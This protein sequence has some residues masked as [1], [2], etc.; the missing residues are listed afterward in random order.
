VGKLKKV[1]IGFGIVIL[2]FFVL[3]AIGGSVPDSEYPSE[4]DYDKM[5]NSQ[6]SAMAVDWD[7]RDLMRNFDNYEN[8]I[9]FVD[10]TVTNIQRSMNSVNL[11]MDMGTFSCDDLMFLRV[12]ENKWLE[13]DELS[14]FVEVIELR[15][16]GNSNMFTG[17]EWV[18]SGEYVPR[19]NEIRLICDNC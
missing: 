7:Y 16:T 18:G 19:V 11:C 14:G 2:S 3:A 6:L 1:G 17:G 15:E 8:Q 10:G 5:S 9:I 4:I 12:N 13:D